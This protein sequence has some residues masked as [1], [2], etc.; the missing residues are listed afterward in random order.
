MNAFVSSLGFDSNSLLMIVVVV[1]VVVSCAFIQ[2]VFRRELE[3]DQYYYL[4]DVSLIAAWAICGI[5]TGSAP[6]KLMI[7]AG[8]IAGLVGFCQKVVKGWDLRF[9]FLAIGFG[10]ALLGPRITFSVLDRKSVV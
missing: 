3:R 7:T 8:V 4:R 6:M 1:L 10:V 5:W 9:C 2:R